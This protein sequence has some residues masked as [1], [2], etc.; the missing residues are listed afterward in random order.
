MGTIADPT[1]GKASPFVGPDLPD[2]DCECSDL[3]VI[4][5]NGGRSWIGNH[6]SKQLISLHPPRGPV[7]ICPTCVAHL[8]LAG[9]HFQRRK[10]R[11]SETDPYF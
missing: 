8:A 10:G 2:A 11:V 3:F 6:S 1:A 7:A 4:S 9:K 5:E